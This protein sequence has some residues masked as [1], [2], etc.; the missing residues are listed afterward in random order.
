MFDTYN[1]MSFPVYSEVNARKNI[2]LLGTSK[3]LEIIDIDSILRIEAISNYSRLYFTNGKSLVVAKVLSWF[4]EKLAHRR[5]IRLH[6]SHL[7]NMQYIRAYNAQNCSEV[8][9]VNDERL[10]VSRRKRIEF[11]KAI[12]QFYSGTAATS[13]SGGARPVVS[14]PKAA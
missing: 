10:T 7:V 1:T 8:V 12:Y 4:E 9:L 6:R 3:G 13:R 11:K 14:I 5:F 2:L